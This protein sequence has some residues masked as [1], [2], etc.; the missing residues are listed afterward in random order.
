MPVLP[1][2]S[3]S[4][5]FLAT[6]WAAKWARYSPD[7]IAV[8]EYDTQRTLSYAELNRNG[9]RLAAYFQSKAFRKGIV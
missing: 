9:S 8:K 7:K 3:K 4:M 5:N 2:N 6:D 1:L